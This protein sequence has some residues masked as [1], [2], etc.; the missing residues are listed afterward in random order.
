MRRDL[1]VVGGLWAGLT[2]VLVLVVSWVDIFP[3]VGAREARVADD[4]FR[5]LMR[6]AAPAF[7]FVLAALVYSLL[8]YRG[9]GDPPSDAP[10]VREHPAVAR[11]WFVLTAALAAA[12][13]YQ[14][15]LVGIADMHGERR[16]DLEVHV[17]A[18]RWGWTFL[19]PP[20]GVKSP[21]LV[22]PTGRRV[23]FVVTSSDVIHSF[24]IPAF[25]T[26]VDAVPG[27]ETV[28][29]VTPTVTGSGSDNA[30]LWVRCA[31]LCGL[32][33][34]VMASLVRVV[35]PA[36]FDTWLATQKPQARGGP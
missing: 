5:L 29:F 34:D 7:S 2:G 23:R 14:P 27:L 19:Y 22:L 11:V 12:V 25:R 9:R 28:L 15:G 3:F 4:A 10:Y 36:E 24:W 6:M 32:G 1:I 8:R 33:H 35:E 20:Y 30:Q 17:Q 18:V 31:E 13:M 21:H 16:A 26:K